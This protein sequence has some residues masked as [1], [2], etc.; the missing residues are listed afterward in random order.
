[1]LTFEKSKSLLC[2]F[3]NYYHHLH[4][5][6]IMERCLDLFTINIPEIRKYR[7]YIFIIELLIFTNK[8]S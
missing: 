5:C 8:N 2:L 7:N 4:N 6:I 1:M 3:A